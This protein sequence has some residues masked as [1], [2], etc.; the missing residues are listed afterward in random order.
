MAPSHKVTVHITQL[1][2]I[3]DNHLIRQGMP[4][5]GVRLMPVEPEE[6]N[7][8]L[9]DQDLSTGYFH[10]A[11]ADPHAKIILTQAHLQQVQVWLIRGP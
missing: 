10:L 4:E 1:L 9:V 5:L 7:G 3:G 2:H 11:Q 6:L 8:A